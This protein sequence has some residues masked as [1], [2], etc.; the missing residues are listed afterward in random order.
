MLAYRRYVAS[1]RNAAAGAP[2]G[3]VDGAH[4]EIVVAPAITI[5]WQGYGSEGH[6]NVEVHAVDALSRHRYFPGSR[7]WRLARPRRAVGRKPA[8]QAVG[9]SRKPALPEKRNR[10]GAG[11]A[12]R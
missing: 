7:G 9:G 11:R 4:L 5:A 3:R 8:P 2:A 1:I 10:M 6:H 12:G